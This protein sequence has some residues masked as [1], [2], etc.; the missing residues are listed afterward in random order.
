MDIPDSTDTQ[1]SSM[2]N[3]DTQDN[4]M[5]I[6]ASIITLDMVIPYLTNMGMVIRMYM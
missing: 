2:A 4:N 3:M 5:H 6:Q 1:V